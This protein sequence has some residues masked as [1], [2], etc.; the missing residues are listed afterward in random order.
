MATPLLVYIN[1]ALF[2]VMSICGVNLLA[3][4]GISIIKWGADF[5]PLYTYR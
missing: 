5:G 3:P 2:V 4:T 1:I